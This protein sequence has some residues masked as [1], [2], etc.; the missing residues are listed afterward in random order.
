MAGRMTQQLKELERKDKNN[1]LDAIEAKEIVAITEFLDEQRKIFDGC[2]EVVYR[3]PH[4]DNNSVP[5]TIRFNK[6]N[7]TTH[8]NNTLLNTIEKD[9]EEI[10]KLQSLGILLNYDVYNGFITISKTFNVNYEDYKKWKENKKL[11]K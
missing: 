6:R 10:E 3:P 9:Y 7:G 2:D 1:S 4:K 11:K 5:R 8:K